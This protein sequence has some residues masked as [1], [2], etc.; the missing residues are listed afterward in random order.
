MTPSACPPPVPGHLFNRVVYGQ[1]LIDRDGEAT[2]VMMTALDAVRANPRAQEHMVTRQILE[3]IGMTRR[4]AEQLQGQVAMEAIRKHWWAFAL[5]TLS[6]LWEQTFL[7]PSPTHWGQPP[8]GTAS[9]VIPKPPGGT[10]AGAMTWIEKLLMLEQHLWPLIATL[11]I[12]GCFLALFRYRSLILCLVGCA[13][14]GLLLAAVTGENVHP[15]YGAPSAPLLVALAMTAFLAP[16]FEKQRDRE[17]DT[18]VAQ[19]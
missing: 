12:F 18:I 10:T 19:P 2:R 16:L 5:G 11:S 15:R 9:D 4:N 1:G 6:N 7:A 14:F 17:H 8:R 13:A 3:A